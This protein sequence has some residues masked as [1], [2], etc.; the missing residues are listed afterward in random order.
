M[1]TNNNQYKDRCFLLPYFRNGTTES[2]TPNCR[3][4][5]AEP[6]TVASK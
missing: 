2:V 5:R 3:I 6:E 1:K 4:N